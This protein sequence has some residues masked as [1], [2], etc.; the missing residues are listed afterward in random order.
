MP[1][2]PKSPSLCSSTGTLEL[3]ARNE[4][5]HSDRITSVAFNPVDGKTIV[6]A[7]HDK[8]IKVWDAGA[9]L[10][11]LLPGTKLTSYPPLAATLEL[12]GEKTNAH[13]LQINSVTFS[14]DGTKIVSACG[15]YRPG[16]I[17]VWDSG[18]LEPQNACPAKINTSWRVHRHSRAQ[19]DKRE[20]PQRHHQ[21]H[22]LQSSG[23]QDDRV[24]LQGPDDQSLGCRCSLFSTATL[25]KN[26]FLISP[27]SHT[28]VEGREEK[29]AQRLHQHSQLFT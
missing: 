8:T 26:D 20:R 22:C 19:S 1:V 18:E 6:S 15:D 5:A 17:K 29:R 16:T 24:W 25:H 21:K 12:K 7:S 9:C 2:L 13:N 28:G 10:S 4:N 3:K 27:C 14:P 11:Q 23:W